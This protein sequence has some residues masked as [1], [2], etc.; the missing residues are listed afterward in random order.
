M[1]IFKYIVSYYPKHQTCE[2][3]YQKTHFLVHLKW[4]LIAHLE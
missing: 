1:Y 4:D 2:M 3:T